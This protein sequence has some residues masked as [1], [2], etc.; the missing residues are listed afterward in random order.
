MRKLLASTHRTADVEVQPALAPQGAFLTREVVVGGCHGGAGVTT[1]ARML[2]R[3]V[4]VGVAM[5]SP[6]GRPL[7]LVTHGTA[8][9]T[10]RAMQLLD[11]APKLGLRVTALIVVGDGPWPEPGPVRHRLR[12]LEGTV[13]AVIRV[14]YVPR[15]RYLDDPLSEPIPP[16]VRTAL[17]AIKSLVDA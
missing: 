6:A 5:P 4:D 10:L 14:P 16:K 15:W 9:R 3:A 17:Y 8:G 12:V 11:R 13:P 2:D 1:L 7:L